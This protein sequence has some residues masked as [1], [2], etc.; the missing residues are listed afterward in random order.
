MNLFTHRHLSML[1]LEGSFS[2]MKQCEYHSWIVKI[3]LLLCNVSIANGLSTPGCTASTSVRQS[4]TVTELPPTLDAIEE[5]TALDYF[6]DMH[7]ARI[8]IA[9]KVPIDK[10]MFQAAIPLQADVSETNKSNKIER[11]D[12]QHTL[13]PIIDFEYLQTVYNSSDKINGRNCMKERYRFFRKVQSRGGCVLVRFDT[14][15][16][17]TSILNDMWST[18]RAFYQNINGEAKKSTISKKRRSGRR[19]DVSA[20]SSLM[21]QHLARPEQAPDTGGYDY[22]QTY[23]DSERKMVVPTTIQDAL[24]SEHTSCLGV[25]ESFYALSD[26]SQMFATV[27]ASGALQRPV[28]EMKC[29]L[30]DVILDGFGCSSH[31]LCQYRRLDNDNSNDRDPMLRSH[32]DWSLVTCIPISPTP[33]LVVFDPYYN[34]WLAPDIAVRSIDHASCHSRYCLLMTGKSMDLLLG[35]EGGMACIHQVVTPFQQQSSNLESSQESEQRLS[36]PFFLRQKESL[37]YQINDKCNRQPCRSES[38]ALSM[39]HKVYCQLHPRN[40]ISNTFHVDY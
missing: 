20:K 13:P 25:E 27:L 36:A 31:R 3:C 17:Y 15:S 21:R 10:S 14:K 6:N 8:E 16:K 38:D 29:F 32:T 23:W 9:D 4:S 22:V 39:L 26:L 5:K 30:N 19:S 1:R 33:G 12:M 37:S 35:V 34:K 2:T 18:M 28:H 24:G 11:I 40:E 7:T